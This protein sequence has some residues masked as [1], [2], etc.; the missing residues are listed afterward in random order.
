LEIEKRI[1]ITFNYR[2]A[3]I[4]LLIFNFSTNLQYPTLALSEKPKPENISS[5]QESLKLDNLQSQLNQIQS[6]Q[7]ILKNE[8]GKKKKD[9]WDKFGVISNSLAS[10][11]V[12]SIGILFTFL[13]NKREQ[14]RQKEDRRQK[15][16]S[17]EEDRRLTEL[18]V[19]SK[20]LPNL[21]G[22]DEI[23][24][25]NTIAAI[26]ELASPR[27]AIKFAALNPSQGTAQA[28]IN[29]TNATET[30]KEERNLAEK[31]LEQI[32][33]RYRASVVLV[34]SEDGGSLCSGF[35]IT[36]NGYILTA[37]FAIGLGKKHKIT[38][39]DKQEF[40]V[41]VIVVKTA[42]ERFCI[43]KANIEN[44]SYIPI[45]E[46]ESKIDDNILVIGS[47]GGAPI[48]PITGRITNITS[49]EIFYNREKRDNY[50]GMAG[51]PIINTEGMV[52]GLHER[53]EGHGSKGIFGYDLT[54]A[55]AVKINKVTIQKYLV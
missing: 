34:K 44:T 24:K 33:E 9:I 28:L 12:P 32:F 38:T 6:E 2:L 8:L 20:L 13:Y 3:L 46:T 31:A 26:G 48:I 42:E 22:N 39:F 19:L 54:Q 15:T 23:L 7:Q 29:I 10:I 27:I 4:L 43:L 25:S 14:E 50:S 52:I 35:F 41:E 36:S 21:G 5:T 30:T 1:M 45:A 55:V 17:E 40:D 18:E 16:V 51:A 49:E 11:L 47:I 37:V 53:H